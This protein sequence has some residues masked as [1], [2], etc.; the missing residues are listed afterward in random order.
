[1]KDRKPPCPRCGNS[2]QKSLSQIADTFKCDKCG[3]M[4]DDDPEEGG[5]YFADPSRRME[6]GESR[7]QTR[8][9]R[10]PKGS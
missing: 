4:Y 3:A 8:A 2:S 7:R 5:D 1:M 10:V 9:K 6:L